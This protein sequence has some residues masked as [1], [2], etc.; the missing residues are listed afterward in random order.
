MLKNYIKI[1]LRSLLKH[2]GYTL[3]NLTGM[4]VGMACCLLIVLYVQDEL[5]YDTYHEKSDR[6]YRVLQSWKK[7]KQ[8]DVLQPPAPEEYQIWGNAPVGPALA[9][10]FPEIREVVRF[11]SPKN[12]L[13]QVGEKR[14]QQKEV[15]FVDSTA[16]K[17]FSWKL[18]K[19]NPDKVLTEPNSLVLTKSIAKKYFG[20][21]NPVGQTIRLDNDFLATVTGVMEDVPQNSHFSFEVLL[22]MSTFHQQYPGP[23]EWWGYVDF[24]TYF[25]VAE[26]AD[27]T[28]LQAKIPDFLMR[29]GFSP[30]EDPYYIALEP[31]SAAYLHSAAER[32]PGKT[33]NLTNLYIFSSIAAFILL[34]A[35][36]NFMNLATARS[37]DRAREVGVRKVIGARKAGLVTQFLTESVVLSFFA[38]VLAL[39]L[40]WLAFPAF[41]QLSGKTFS[42]DLLLSWMVLLFVLGAV[43]LVGVLGGSYPAWVLARFRPALVLKG[44]FSSSAAG[45][46]LRKG[47]VVFQFSLSMG[48]IAGTAIVFSQLNHLRT[49]DLGFQQEQM[50]LIDFGYDETIG[51]KAELMK[52]QFLQHP[53]VSSVS[54]SRSV[55]G[56]FIPNAGTSVQ[57]AQGDMEMQDPQRKK[58]QR[59]RLE[60][61]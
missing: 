59:I 57:T 17:V 13:F 23:F 56:D 27:I 58:E 2:K 60:T 32:Q 38:G 49:Q 16:F 1:A 54:V 8:A 7:T 12:F 34:I 40:A 55:P 22:S 33:G 31:L 44:V 51:Q 36:I 50:L 24:Y 6:M 19:G 10:D 53:A 42:A 48:L 3:I 45:I 20:E 15:L 52:Q 9:A 21:S 39:V 18:L 29:H 30:E 35:C 61:E 28:S 37:A 26:G 14:F 11:T 5:S 43:L 47:L 25:T 4:A 46:A 41:Q